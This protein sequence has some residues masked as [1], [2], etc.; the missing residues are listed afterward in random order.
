MERT[1]ALELVKTHLKNQNLIKHVLAVE[2]IMRG[3]AQHQGADPDAWGLCG[4]LHDLD[5]DVTKDQPER[6][7][8]VTA[9]ILTA[10]QISESIIYA[11]KCH[12]HQA[13]IKSAL[14]QALYVADPVSGFIV[15]AAL[16]HPE[17][18]LA[19]LDVAFLNNR[20]REKRFAAGANRTQMLECEKLGLSLDA[21]LGLALQAMQQAHQVLGL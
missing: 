2:A 1:V 12:N 6:H 10:Y 21:F 19:A 8:H 13:E 16:M 9:D 18:K 4:L 7:T 14:D 15:A 20:F 17:K 11:I 3:L 5:Y